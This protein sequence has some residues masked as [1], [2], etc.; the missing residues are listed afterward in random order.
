MSQ[1]KFSSWGSCKGKTTAAAVVFL[2]PRPTTDR[3]TFLG[4]WLKWNLHQAKFPSSPP[5]S[6]S[7][8]IQL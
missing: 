3:V 7:H 5:Y 4:C 2:D 1:N 6:T 8:H